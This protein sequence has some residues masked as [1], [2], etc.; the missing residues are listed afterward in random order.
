M[1]SA[2]SG[3]IC[4]RLGREPSITA[5]SLRHTAGTMA[6]DSY[7]CQMWGNDPMKAFTTIFD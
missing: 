3:K 1:G 5:H 2:L 7:E 6:L 4:V